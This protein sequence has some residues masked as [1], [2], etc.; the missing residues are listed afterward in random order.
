MRCAYYGVVIHA[1]NSSAR[2]LPPRKK[3]RRS[4]D[5]RVDGEKD[6]KV[7]SVILP[8]CK[9]EQRVGGGGLVGEWTAGGRGPL[10]V[11]IPTAIKAMR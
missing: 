5:R 4:F 8:K 7:Y 6:N 10:P 9:D 11:G 2:P 1:V 3:R